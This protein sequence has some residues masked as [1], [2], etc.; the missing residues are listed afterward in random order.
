MAGDG[1][2]PSLLVLRDSKQTLPDCPPPRAGDPSRLINIASRV[3][4]SQS[5]CE[6]ALSV[7][8]CEFLFASKPFKCEVG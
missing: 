2:F 5:H 8:H 6:V 1:N 3:S 4:S 7:V